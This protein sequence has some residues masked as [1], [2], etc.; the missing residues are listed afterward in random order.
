MIYRDATAADLPAIDALFR[1]SFVATFGHLYRPEDLAAFLA[2]F[3]PEAWAGELATP[4]LR[5]QL[6]EDEQ[7]LAGFAKTSALTLPAETQ[8]RTHELRQL[9]LDERAKGSGA[10][11]T[12]LDWALDEGRARGAEEMWLSVYVDNHRARRFYEKN[13]FEDRGTYAFMVGEHADEDRLMRR[14]L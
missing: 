12:L 9:Y 14:K 7:G 6:A 2:G 5:F 4:D 3:T 13:G 10:A 8:A 1:A 11:Q